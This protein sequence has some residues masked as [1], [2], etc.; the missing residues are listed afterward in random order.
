MS[1]DIRNKKVLFL[2]YGAVAKCV[3]NYFD[4][5]FTFNRRRVVLVDKTKSAFTGPNLKDVK[6]IVMS[7]DSTNFEELIDRIKLKKHDIIIDLT[8]ST[9]T[10][11]FIKM[12]FMHGFHYI[13]TSIEDRNDAML[14][15]SIDCQQ[16]MIETIADQFPHPTSTILTEF[17]QNPGL[18]QHYIIFALNE[19]KKLGKKL[20]K[21]KGKGTNKEYSRDVLTKV[22]DEFKVGTILMSE[23]DNM[24]IASSSSSSSKPLV[25]GI[26]YNTWSVTGYV[27]EAEDKTELVCGKKNDFVHPIIPSEKFSDFT[28]SLYDKLRG[29]SQ[30]YD[31]LFLKKSGLQTT[32]N[33]ICPVLDENGEIVITNYRGK[34]IHHGEIFN[35]ARYFGENAPFMSY[36]YQSS[37]YVDQSI[38]SFQ[39]QN[40]AD[41]KDLWL[42]VNQDQTYHIFE[43]SEVTGHDS[44]GCTLFC[45]DKSVDRIFWCG[46]ILSISDA[47][48]ERQY[49][50]TIVQVAAG[51]L[52]GLSAILE[53]GNKYKG[54]IEPTDLDTH[55]ILKKSVP[56]LGKFRFMEIPASEFKGPIEYKEI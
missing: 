45:G 16:H 33:S 1:I 44:V 26:I 4:K 34:L 49:T 43:G 21:G 22:I 3:W 46:S 54:W 11:Y 2:G 19:M 10:Y 8:T 25:P 48:V 14:G 41:M 27:F 17:G 6:K 52:S 51:V 50:P 29:S 28:I 20:D 37:P 39:E 56:L 42:H 55:N 7:V 35:M 47:C 23:I 5:Y 15:T 53:P 18:V 32:L 13:N 9:V 12:C 40:N 38:Q 30:P 31:I 36:V 24:K